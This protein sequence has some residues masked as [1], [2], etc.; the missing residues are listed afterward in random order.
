M[1]CNDFHHWLTARD[2]QDCVLPRD[3]VSHMAVC[4]EC[5]QLFKKDSELEQEISR[6]FSLVEL[7]HSLADRVDVSLD[8]ESKN[9]FLSV[10]LKKAGIALTAT[11]IFAG[12]IILVLSIIQYLSPGSPIFKDLNQ[13]SHQAVSDHLQGNRYMTF[14]ARETE[15]ALTLLTRE[16][17]FKVLLPD[18]DALGCVLLGGRLCA[19]GDCRAAYLVVEKEGKAGSLFIMNTD[20]LAFDMTDGSRFLT[21]IKGCDTQIWKN[22]GQIYAMVF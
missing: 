20:H 11:S 13:I 8:H 19:L 22:H 21:S 16:L 9:R 6:A 5:E 10:Y 18:F 12:A 14:D 2:I 3:A 17:G 7:P 4:H 1:D 15:D